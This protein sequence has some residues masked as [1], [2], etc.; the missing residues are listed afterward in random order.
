MRVIIL[1]LK[2]ITSQLCSTLLPTKLDITK[3]NLAYFDI[4]RNT[5]FVR[6]DDVFVLHTSILKVFVRRCWVYSPRNLPHSFLLSGPSI[7]TSF[8]CQQHCKKMH[9][10]T[11]YRTLFRTNSKIHTFP[12]KT[13]PKNL[14]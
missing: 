12:T 4:P 14:T 7:S 2:N 5:V 11:T 9:D 8:L 6:H 10:R 3:Q 13:P 1:P